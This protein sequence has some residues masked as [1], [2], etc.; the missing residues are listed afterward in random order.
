MGRVIYV[1]INK[2]TK[3]MHKRNDGC[4]EVEKTEASS[5]FEAQRKFGGNPI[6][7]LSEGEFNKLVQ[8]VEEKF[9]A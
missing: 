9:R 7:I 4:F 8:K 5:R 6:L 2:D 3:S 1:A